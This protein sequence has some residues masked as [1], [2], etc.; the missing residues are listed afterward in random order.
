MVTEEILLEN[1]RKLKPEKQQQV[2]EFVEQLKSESETTSLESDFVP[3]TPL[4]KKLWSI[5]QR[6]I[7]DKY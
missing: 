5:R 1:W 7:A 3:E 6:A 2:L 4:A